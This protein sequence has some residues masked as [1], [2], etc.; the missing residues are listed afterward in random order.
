MS[1]ARVLVIDDNTDLTTIISLVLTAEGFEVKICN[2]VEGAIFCLEDWQPQIIL[3]DVNVNGQDGRE[4]CQKIKTE[5][6]D[7]VRIILM[8]GDETL[9]NI[10]KA[11]GADHCIVKPFDTDQLV[12]QISLYSMQ[13]A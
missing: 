7:E 6:G 12:Q 2:D 3:L 1:Q 10:T 8:S 11:A 5:R 4:L 13:K 9:L